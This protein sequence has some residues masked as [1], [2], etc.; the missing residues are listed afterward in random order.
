MRA[1]HIFH[2]SRG[3]AVFAD[4][5][6]WVLSRSSRAVPEGNIALAGERWRQLSYIG[7]T[8]RILERCI[9]EKGA[10]VDKQ[11]RRDLDELPATFSEWRLGRRLPRAT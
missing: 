5:Q 8:K 6:Q 4:D 2:L 10:E 3:W 1:E 7:T 9:R 11:G